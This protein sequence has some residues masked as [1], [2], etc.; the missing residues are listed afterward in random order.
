MNETNDAAEKVGSIEIIALSLRGAIRYMQRAIDLLDK[1]ET[2]EATVAVQQLAVQRLEGLL[3][4]F[5]EDDSAGQENQPPGEN[6]EGQQPGPGGDIVTLITQ[7]QVIR[8]LQLDLA[9]RY[10][11]VRG[12]AGSDAELTETDQ[13]ELR[14]LSEEQE[15]IADLVREMTSAFGDAESEPDAEEPLAVPGGLLD[16]D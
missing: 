1:R 4:A 15:L 12:R 16:E 2:G 13:A 3:N 9:E 5:S 8:S 10:R 6:G 14:S 11:E 7:L